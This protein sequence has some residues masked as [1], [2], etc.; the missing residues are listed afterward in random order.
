MEA[1]IP[2]TPMRPTILFAVTLLLSS[3]SFAQHFPGPFLSPC[4]GKRAGEACTVSKGHDSVVGVCTAGA[5]GD[6]LACLPPVCAQCGDGFVTPEA[7]EQCDPGPA[8][9]T[10]ACNINCTHSV[11]GDG[12]VNPAAHEQCDTGVP[13]VPSS[14][15]NANC[16]VSRCGDGIVN[17]AAFEQCDEGAETAA[18]T[19]RCTISACGDGYVNHAAGEECDTG[20]VPSATC[21]ADCK[22]KRLLRTFPAGPTSAVCPGGNVGGGW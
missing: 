21:T 8:G 5:T 22:I 12:I 7:G 1:R 2:E 9:F 15:C 14:F 18:C 4:A 17:P 20:G 19:G 11:C 6:D 13:G 16:T 10:A 3:P